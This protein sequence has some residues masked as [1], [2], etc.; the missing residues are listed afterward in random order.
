MLTPEVSRLAET[1][2]GLLLP[3]LLLAALPTYRAFASAPSAAS[4]A[5]S[6]RPCSRRAAR[7][8]SAKW[9][10]TD[11]AIVAIPRRHHECALRQCQGHCI[12]E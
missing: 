8:M 5:L 11:R 6:T 3:L 1:V 10:A 4:S 9:I 2:A 12:A 7:P